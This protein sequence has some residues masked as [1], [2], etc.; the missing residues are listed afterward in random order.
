MVLMMIPSTVAKDW[1]IKNLKRE[2]WCPWVHSPKCTD[3]KAFCQCGKT[4]SKA[5]QVFCYRWNEITKPI[6]VH[7]GIIS[8]GD[9]RPSKF[10]SPRAPR[11]FF[12]SFNPTT[13]IQVDERRR[14][15]VRALDFP[16]CRRTSL[17]LAGKPRKRVI[18]LSRRIKYFRL[19]QS[20][21]TRSGSE[22]CLLKFYVAPYARVANHKYNIP[23]APMLRSHLTYGCLVTTYWFYH[24]Y[25]YNKT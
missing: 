8:P 1:L 15:A 9:V 6:E 18:T 23:R 25:D 21:R 22:R 13:R 11:C 7:G 14:K 12:L 16:D 2:I 4:K 20:L 10:R 3:A 24:W 5:K 19:W 17:V